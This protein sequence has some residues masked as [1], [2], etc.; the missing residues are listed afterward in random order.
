MKWTSGSSNVAGT[1]FI[2]SWAIIFL[3]MFSGQCSGTHSTNTQTDKKEDQVSGQTLEKPKTTETKPSTQTP[4]APKQPQYADNRWPTTSPD[5][6][7]IP[8]ENRWYNAWNY[9]GTSCTIAGPVKRV[10][11]AKESSGM[12]IF[13]DIGE[14][15]P[16]QNA[17][18]LL[19]WGDQYYDFE[20]MINAVDDGGAWLQVSGYLSVYEGQLQFDAGEGYIEY[21]W[22]A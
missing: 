21:T 6:L 7:A 14:A 10:Y 2:A 17:V 8:E 16:N 5:L 18:T 15:Y 3:L 13:I 1:L 22:W 20:E 4:T 12:P 9:A 11:Q 19:V